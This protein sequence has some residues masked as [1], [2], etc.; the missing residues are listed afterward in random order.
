MF[1]FEDEKKCVINIPQL[2][3]DLDKKPIEREPPNGTVVSQVSWTGVDLSRIHDIY[4]GAGEYAVSRKKYVLID[5]AG[6][7][8]LYSGITH[9]CHPASVS[10]SDPKVAEKEVAVRRLNAVPL[11]KAGNEDVKYEV[12]E[13]K[14]FSLLRSEIISAGKVLDHKKLDRIK[15]PDLS[16]KPVVISGRLPH[17]FT[18]SLA[19]TYAHKVPWVACHQPNAGATVSI[20]HD[21]ETRLGT[22]VPDEKVNETLCSQYYESLSPSGPEKK[23]AENPKM[24]LKLSL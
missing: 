21:P 6:P 18:V 8:F 4:H 22:V 19:N 14:D 16:G 3:D 1:H 7:A 10:I 15:C 23:L 2:A 17:W 5:G 13:G 20:T 11:E 9:S 12:H 24:R